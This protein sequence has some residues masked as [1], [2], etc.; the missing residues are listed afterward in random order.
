VSVAER[1]KSLFRE[2]AVGIFVA[3]AASAVWALIQ[4]YMAGGSASWSSSVE[5]GAAIGGAYSTWKIIGTAYILLIVLILTA[6]AGF[7]IVVA[8]A[9]S[10]LLL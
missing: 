9:S 5:H 1:S 4:H 3:V 6:I 7:A 8:L 10:I 2:I